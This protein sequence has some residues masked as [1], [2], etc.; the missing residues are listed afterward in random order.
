MRP[1]MRRG[2]YCIRF[3]RVFTNAVSWSRLC[4][5]RLASDPLQVRPHTLDGVEFG[6][7]WR[8]LVDG[9]P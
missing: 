4:L 9:Q 7:V 8:Q 6:S 5:V 2:R 1:S 3:S